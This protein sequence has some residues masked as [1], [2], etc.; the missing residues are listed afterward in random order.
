MDQSIQVLGAEFVVS[1]RYAWPEVPFDPDG[2]ELSHSSNGVLE[3]TC[4]QALPS[5]VGDTDRNDVRRGIRTDHD[6][7][8]TVG[9]A[10]GEYRSRNL[11]DGSVR[12][13]AVMTT[14]FVDQH[15]GRSVDLGKKSP[16]CVDQGSTA[17]VEFFAIDRGS[18]VAVA[19]I[20][21]RPSG[22]HLVAAAR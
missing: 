14:G 12:L 6:D 3:D 13:R 16:G 17:F 2:T 5:G 11:R 15:D 10:D 4:Q 20:G 19:P 9:C 1:G 21:E 22:T 18:E 7:T 8:G